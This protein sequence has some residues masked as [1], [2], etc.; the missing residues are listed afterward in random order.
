VWSHLR[1]AGQNLTESIKL[2]PTFAL[3]L[4]LASQLPK[5]YQFCVYLNNL[6]LNLAVA[7]CLLAMGIYCIGTTRKKALDVPQRL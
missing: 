5:Q 7:Q 6:F 1:S 3:V 2:A 4:R